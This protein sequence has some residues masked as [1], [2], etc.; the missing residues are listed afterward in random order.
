MNRGDE[1]G[2]GRSRIG[3]HEAKAREGSSTPVLEISAVRPMWRH[4]TEEK[5]GGGRGTKATTVEGAERSIREVTENK[6]VPTGKSKH[7]ITKDVRSQA[8]QEGVPQ[9]EAATSCW[10]TCPS[11]WKMQRTG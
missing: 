7:D 3:G 2:K 10:E 9:D 6:G 5:E 1:K 8:G 11:G 4:K